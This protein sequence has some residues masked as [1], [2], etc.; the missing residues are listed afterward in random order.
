MEYSF[1]W[2]GMTERICGFQFCCSICTCKVKF[3]GTV[4]WDFRFQVFSWIVS[5]KPLNRVSHLGL[6]WIFSKFC[7]NI[8]SSRCTAGAVVAGGKFTTGVVDI[9]GSMTPVSLTLA[10]NLLPVWLTTLANL[11]RWG[12]QM[13]FKSANFFDMWVQKFQLR[14]FLFIELQSQIRKFLSW[15]VRKLQILR[16]FTI[17]QRE[18]NILFFPSLYSKTI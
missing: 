6:F 16:F 7:G 3:K 12:V 4:P 13:F 18:W 17:R 2:I 15:A 14:K 5:L 1:S 10:A 9:E 11:Q 8:H